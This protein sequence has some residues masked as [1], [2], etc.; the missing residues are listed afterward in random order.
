VTKD[1]ILQKGIEDGEYTR[2]TGEFDHVS[3]EA[4]FDSP[5]DHEL[6][7]TGLIDAAYLHRSVA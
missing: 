6:Y 7:L 2:L 4:D 1:E 5:E 3:F